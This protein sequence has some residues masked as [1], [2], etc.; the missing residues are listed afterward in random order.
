[1]TTDPLSNAAPVALDLEAVRLDVRRFLDEDVGSGDETTRRTIPPSLAGR[2]EIVARES[3]VVAGLSVARLVFEELD[4]GIVFSAHVEDGAM[5]KGGTP[6]ATVEGPV[7]SILTGERVALNLL[8]RLSGIATVTRRY[9]GALAG[10]LASVSDTRKTTPG[11]RR[12]EKYAVRVGGGRNHRIG[13]FDAILI[14]DNHIAA[15]G[16]IAA[17]LNAVEAASG[18]SLPVQVE[19]DTL[20]D[21]AEALACGARAVLLDNMAPSQVSAAVRMIR[22]HPN[23]ADCWI[24]ASGGITLRDIRAYAEAGVDT[25]S[26]GALTHSAPSVDIALDLAG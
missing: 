11:L 2:G 20:A 14:K 13:L 9:A 22:A 7:G 8:Q 5:V 10:T 3:V 24:E 16:G 6:L 15:A 17:A 21:L 23:G 26:V 4:R 1:M 12:L 25:I 18:L 19:V